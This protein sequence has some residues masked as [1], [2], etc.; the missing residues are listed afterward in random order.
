MGKLNQLKS[1]DS[2]KY[3]NVGQGNGIIAK[4]KDETFVF[5]LGTTSKMYL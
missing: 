5:D 3:L 1:F 4:T 2:I